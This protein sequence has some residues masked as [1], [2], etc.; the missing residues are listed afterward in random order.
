MRNV[1]LTYAATVAAGTHTISY[2]LANGYTGEAK[3]LVD[4]K[5]VSGYTFTAEGEF[6]NKEGFDEYI[7][8]LQGIEKIPT[9]VGGT[10]DGSQPNDDGMTLTDILL[11]VLVVL[12]VIMAII[13]ALRMMRS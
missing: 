1:G 9:E 10:T 3:M 8:T 12:I 11:I 7:I 4:G 5:E 6:D 13:V 2:T